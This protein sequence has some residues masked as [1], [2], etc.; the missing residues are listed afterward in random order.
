MNSRYEAIRQAIF[1]ATDGLASPTVV[2]AP[3]LSMMQWS[4]RAKEGASLPVLRQSVNVLRAGDGLL[5]VGGD[6][7]L[8]AA[9]WAVASVLAER[10][11]VDSA[12]GDRWFEPNLPSPV[13]HDIIELFGT[14]RDAEALFASAG[15]NNSIVDRLEISARARNLMRDRLDAGYSLLLPARTTLSLGKKYGW[16]VVDGAHGT[17]FDEL[18]DGTHGDL[19]EE[20][21]IIDKIPRFARR[22]YCAL[23]LAV[24]GVALAAV[25][26][27]PTP[28]SVKQV[29][30]IAGSLA[31]AEKN[32][33]KVQQAGKAV[34]SR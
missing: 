13:H 2:T 29:S 1:A 16:W 26:S 18:E 4:T 32:R 28:Q 27:M 30:D 33:Q 21:F 8:R 20:P 3:S 14:G 22:R 25:V 24:A 17:L 7:T 10:F 5:P 31:D 12:A 6:L 23:H 34:C 11:L 19:E 9:R 15:E